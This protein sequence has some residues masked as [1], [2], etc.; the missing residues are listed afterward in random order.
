MSGDQ[1]S[2]YGL[3]FDHEGYVAF[4]RALGDGDK[5]YVFTAEGVEGAAGNAGSAPHVF[6]DDGDD[7]DVRIDGDVLDFLVREI[8]SKFFAQGFDGSLGVHSGND[9]ADV[10]LRGRLRNQED[11]GADFGG[12]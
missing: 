1:G 10:V 12:G 3:L 11:V 9:E 5:I 6:S 2:F 4:G 8:M 7:G